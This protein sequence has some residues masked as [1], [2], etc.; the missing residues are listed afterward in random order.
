MRN[1]I[2]SGIR[3]VDSFTISGLIDGN[4]QFAVI[5]EPNMR[6]LSNRDVA[7]V[8]SLANE[9]STDLGACGIGFPSKL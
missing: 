6:S 7:G 3:A 2:V 4:L 8:I 9:E 5:T 1:G